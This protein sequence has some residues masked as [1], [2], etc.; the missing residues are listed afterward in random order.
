MA[1]TVKIK[2]KHTYSTSKVGTIVKEGEIMEIMIQGS[3]PIER[4]VVEAF[5][6]KMGVKS[7][8]DLGLATSVQSWVVI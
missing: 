8:S 7:T 4:D 5:R 1:N 3:K 2:F 6:I